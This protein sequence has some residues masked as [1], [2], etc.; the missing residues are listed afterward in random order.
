MQS[1]MEE[2]RKKKSNVN[3]TFINVCI[4]YTKKKKNRWVNK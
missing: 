1:K 2:E 4:A 3:N